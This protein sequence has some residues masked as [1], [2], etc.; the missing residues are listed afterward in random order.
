MS[1][2]AAQLREI[3]QRQDRAKSNRLYGYGKSLGH[4]QFPIENDERFKGQVIFTA[5]DAQSN[6]ADLGSASLYLPRG[7]NFSDAA[8]YD[9]IDLGLIG[10]GAE[11]V[12]NVAKSQSLSSLA[13]QASTTAKAL[14]SISTQGLENQIQTGF[15]QIDDLASKLATGDI[16]A[17]L[18]IIQRALPLVPIGGQELEAGVRSATRTSA[19]PHKRSLFRD[20]GMR[21]FTFSFA[22]APSSAA[23]AAAVNSIIKFFRFNLYPEKILSKSTYKFPSIFDI[24]FYYNGEMTNV[25]KIK[26]CYLVSFATNFNPNNGAMFE[27]GNFSETEIALTFQEERPLDREDIADGF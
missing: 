15:S 6:V 12:G 13:N 24:K 4:S 1:G 27:D 20:V 17:T 23:E 25:P 16:S 22:L 18:P 5:K 21:T 10:V 11:A 2:Y 26:D 3:S 19:N 7:L 8:A 9:N 14:N